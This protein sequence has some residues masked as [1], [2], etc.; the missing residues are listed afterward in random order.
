MRSFPACRLTTGI[1]LATAGPGGLIQQAVLL[2]RQVSSITV[3]QGQLPAMQKHLGKG[4][5][6]AE[7]KRS[8][9][10]P[11]GQIERAQS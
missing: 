9:E 5:S 11:G 7:K 4:C 10:S 2:L 1:W 3:V 6:R 8:G